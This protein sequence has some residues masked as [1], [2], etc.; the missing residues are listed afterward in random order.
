MYEFSILN[1]ERMIRRFL[2][3]CLTYISLKFSDI[4]TTTSQEDIKFLKSNYKVDSKKIKC[5]A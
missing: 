4:Y 3:N 2:L 5:L 1:N